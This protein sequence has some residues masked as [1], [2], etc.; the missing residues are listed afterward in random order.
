MIRFKCIGQR[1]LGG[2]RVKI[3]HICRMFTDDL[4]YQENYLTKFQKRMGF[5]VTVVTSN[6]KMN[7]SGKM[8]KKDSNNTYIN[9]DGIKVIE[10]TIKNEKNY[11]YKF[12][13][14]SNLVETVTGENPD[15]LFIHGCAV[16]Y[17]GDLKNYIKEKNVVVYVDNHSDFSNSARTWISRNILHKIWWKLRIRMIEPYVKRFY[18][19]LP[20]RV[21]F[22]TDVYGVPSDKCELL[23]M[24]ADDDEVTLVKDEK[25]SS[26]LKPKLGID[27]DM[28]V[29]LTGG[30]IDKSKRQT[31]LLMRAINKIKNPKAVLIIFGSI[32]EDIK[33]E[34]NELLSDY[35][36]YVGWIKAKET[37]LYIQIADLV[38]FPG[39]HSVLWEQCVAQEKPMVVKY[40]DG[41]THIDIG[42]NVK[43][44]RKDSEEEI[45][46]IIKGLVDDKEEY[47]KMLKAAK[48]ELSHKFLY[49]E[50]SKQSIIDLL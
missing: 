3:L 26:D 19:V 12:A 50:I 10:L 44:L 33:D 37:Y 45:E 21:K 24:G 4:S 38:V 29:I 17:L 32:E 8:C 7:D 28:F 2:N 11:Y 41:T 23:V 30:K 35:I 5:D 46:E 47:I 31:L 49:S 48:N 1:G 16:M 40:W 42:G 20:A 9:K 14:L 13:Q 22:L 15:C 34:F 18:G 43:Y 39:R 36:R 27:D 6:W 25:I